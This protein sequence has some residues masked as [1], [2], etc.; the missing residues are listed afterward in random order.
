MGEWPQDSEQAGRIEV[1]LVHREALVRSKAED[2]F[3]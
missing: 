1:A 3:S 2:V